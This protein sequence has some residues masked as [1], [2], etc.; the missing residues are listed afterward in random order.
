MYK[1]RITGKGLTKA[2]Y[3]NSQ[4]GVNSDP[5]SIS[6]TRPN[7][8]TDPEESPEP[9]DNITTSSTFGQTNALPGLF[10]NMD[11]TD[12]K[13]NADGTFQQ[14]YDVSLLGAQPNKRMGNKYN[15]W[16]KKKYFPNDKK[17]F[18]NLG[19]AR[20]SGVGLNIFGNIANEIENQGK[21]K[22][23]NK[24]FRQQN[25]PDNMYAVGPG[26]DRG[27]FDINEGIYRPNQ[28]TPP[29]PGAFNTA[30]FGGS[31]VLNNPDM[32]VRIRITSGPSMMK[33]GGQSGLGLGLDIGQRRVYTDMPKDK[34]K[35]V[36]QTIKEVPRNQA[37]IE[38]EKG[39]TVYGDIDGDG[40]FEHFNIGGKRHTE[41]GT[42]LN[43]PEGSF[44]FS[45][46]KKM[47]IKDP[48]I[49]LEFAM[50][51]RKEGYTPAEIAKKYDVN[52]YK[53]IMEDSNADPVRKSTAQLMIKNFQKKLAKLAL[54]Q[55]GMKGFPQ[56]IPKVALDTLPEAAAMQEAMQQTQQLEEGQPN[57]E[58]EMMMEEQVPSEEMMEQPPMQ[59]YGGPQGSLN[60]YQAGT[61]VGYTPTYSDPSMVS[62]TIGS[63][64]NPSAQQ[65]S[66]TPLTQEE[67]QR[68]YPWFKPYT[69]S[70]TEEGRISRT[71][72]RDTLFDPS[73]P[74]QYNDVDYWVQDAKNKGIDINNIEDLQR[75]IY[76][77]LETE[78][79]AAV[80]Q[81]W[82]EYGPT[83]KSDE[84]NLENFADAKAGARTAFAA[85]RRRKPTDQT[86]IGFKCVT[87]PDGTRSVQ[88]SSYMTQN[89]MAVAGAS[90][91]EAAVRARCN[92]SVTPG[93]INRGGKK[94]SAPYGW[95]TPDIVNM[96]AASAVPPKKYL[97]YIAPAPYES[98]RLSLEDWRAQ[99]A[100][101]QSMYNKQ[102]EMMGVYGPT[103]GQGANQ[104]L[105]A[106]QQA[107]GLAGDIAGVT[108]RNVDRVNQFLQGERQRKDQFNL[109][110]A[111][112][113]T[114]L[115]KGNV[116]AN[117]QYD[118]ARRQY[119]NNM[120]KTFG[121]GWGNASKL[122]MLNAINP[123]FQVNPYSGRSFFT[124][125][126]YGTDKF[127]RSSGGSGSGD[128]ASIQSDYLKAKRDAPELSFSE[129]MKYAGVGGKNKS[130]E[131]YDQSRQMAQMYGFNFN[132]FEAMGS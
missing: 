128:W 42:P 109:L 96:A 55:E 132:P 127:G 131:D 41:G 5:F 85:S 119:I 66:A 126:G 10:S 4:V 74:S 65:Q 43:V 11:Q 108:S 79:P 8:L 25:L 69:Q 99:A 30:Q 52:K 86:I 102:G 81:M 101:R 18:Q 114:E 75:Y 95:M 116:V 124:G 121:Q 45:D 47:I 24:W 48:N 105:A 3:Q 2:Q 120:A 37:N 112:R 89:D 32:P 33:Y 106:G 29:N 17:N 97:P 63:G 104:S 80:D 31:M 26:N 78:D 20:F 38:A 12:R 107:E 70:V 73:A 68:K 117:Q 88:S 14:K 87:N 9:E 16:F 98:N 90:S 39:E 51:P 77:E 22:E 13:Y 84:K 125:Q 23:W 56:G 53:A 62:P 91:D 111:N 27:D 21:Q 118:N 15:N 129:Y 35:Q 122:G 50:A 44:I 94:Q 28:L 36:S 130:L 19:L 83:L 110:G 59:R 64:F 57:P 61:Q 72:G 6:Y 103:S 40:A 115:Y 58:E 92:N 46:T 71:T 7:P 82:T 67:L 49:L 93:R 76:K 54:I 34:D 60:K 1:I 113:S 123:M 100:A